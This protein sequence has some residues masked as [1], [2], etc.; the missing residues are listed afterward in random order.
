MGDP[1][2]K[3]GRH[4][5]LRVDPVVSHCVRDDTLLLL[6]LL[7]RSLGN[8]HYQTALWACGHPADRAPRQLVKRKE[9]RS[10]ARAEALRG[11]LHPRPSAFF[12]ESVV[13]S[14]SLFGTPMMVVLKP[15]GFKS[16]LCHF[17]AV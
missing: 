16:H 14:L 10:S 3:A 15:P 7:A 4:T 11:P 2:W 6:Q 1:A 17:L 12:E 13:Q 8:S 9:N 5:A